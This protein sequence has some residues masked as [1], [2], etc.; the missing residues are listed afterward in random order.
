[1]HGVEGILGVILLGVF[2]NAHV[3]AA[4][5]NGLI[6]DNPDFLFKLNES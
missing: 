1:M 2:A 3:N 4:G 5:I 6:H